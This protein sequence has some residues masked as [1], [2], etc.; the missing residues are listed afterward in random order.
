MGLSLC[1][2]CMGVVV[3]NT[4]TMRVDFYV[5]LHCLAES[6]FISLL[7]ETLQLDHQQVKQL[8]DMCGYYASVITSYPGV[9]F[10]CTPEQLVCFLV[11]RN[12]R[13]FKNTWKE[14]D[15][16]YTIENCGPNYLHVDSRK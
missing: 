15:F 11:T 2:A 16:S 8:K 1:L 7:E 4:T 9:H 12:E 6:G 5:G 14:H 10:T 3:S 13:G